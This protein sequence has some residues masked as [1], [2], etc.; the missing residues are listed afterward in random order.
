MMR[1]LP[2]DHIS[3][4]EPMTQQNY[5]VAMSYYRQKRIM[6]ENQF[7]NQLKVNFEDVRQAFNMTL[8]Q[9]WGKKIELLTS[10]LQSHPIND[11]KGGYYYTT[12]AT[13]TP[14][15]DPQVDRIISIVAGRGALGQASNPKAMLGSTFEPFV[16]DK[17]FNNSNLDGAIKDVIQSGMGNIFTQVT[18]GKT[19]KTAIQGGTPQIGPDVMVSIGGGFNFHK[20]NG[21]L[22][23]GNTPIAIELQNEIDLQVTDDN[24]LLS[25]MQDYL[26]SNLSGFNLKYFLKPGG[27]VF[28]SSTV[29]QNRINSVFRQ[30][31]DGSY[32]T[33]EEEYATAYA[34]W[35]V[36]KYLINLINPNVVAIVTGAEFQWVDAFLEAHRLRMRVQRAA[37]SH[38][39]KML[40][41]S[42]YRNGRPSTET[43]PLIKTADVYI[44][45]LRGLRRS[46]AIASKRSGGNIS[47]R[48]E[49]RRIAF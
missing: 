47:V 1:Y 7:Y 41:F 46:K 32:H 40:P 28:T 13:Y 37:T 43:L 30:R 10:S 36:S 6:F 22:T 21:V 33:W 18:G 48:S 27:K 34:N 16:R 4:Y 49:L 12:T 3:I 39:G 17:I 38:G 8:E 29:L 14:G 5:S 24:T 26:K 9:E 45:T 44:Q 20:N 11:G 15:S 25:L 42:S 35:E 23:G 2:Q 19:S 31:H